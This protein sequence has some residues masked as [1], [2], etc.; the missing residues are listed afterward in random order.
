MK[1]LRRPQL[2]AVLE[3]NIG[4]SANSSSIALRSQLRAST[5]F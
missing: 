5:I 2:E 4:G 3:R 1:I